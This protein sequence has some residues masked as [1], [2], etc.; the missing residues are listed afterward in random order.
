MAAMRTLALL[1]FAL[2]ACG[3]PVAPA[4]EPAPAGGI[5]ITDARAGPTPNG[6][7]VSAGYLTIVNNGAEADRLVSAASARAAS[8]ELHTMSMDGAVMRM[9]PIEGG[10]AIPAGGAAVFA[11]GGAHLMFMGVTAPFA[12]GESVAVTLTF[13]RGGEINVDLPVR[14]DVGGH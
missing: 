9:R 10:V 3:A 7:D 13:E 5:E 8:V 14:R 11:P 12:E 4:P 2:A 6:V 1:A